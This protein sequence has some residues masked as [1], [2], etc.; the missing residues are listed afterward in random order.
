[1]RGEN[2]K[3]LFFFHSPKSQYHKWP[4]C[5][6]DSK[7][8]WPIVGI[9]SLHQCLSASYENL[10]TDKVFSKYL[11]FSK[12]TSPQLADSNPRP[13]L[14]SKV[15]PDHSKIALL[16]NAYMLNVFISYWRY[17][18]TH[19]APF[20]LSSG[21]DYLRSSWTILIYGLVW[22]GGDSLHTFQRRGVPV[23]ILRTFPK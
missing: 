2:L 15:E 17:W 4:A 8:F 13:L 5:G 18:M 10:N 1:M 12:R 11:N 7:C 23:S 6:Q 20:H 19:N 22:G 14:H 16:W 9:V 21:N 3:I